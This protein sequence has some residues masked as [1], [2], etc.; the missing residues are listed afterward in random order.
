[1]CVSCVLVSVSAPCPEAMS[2]SPPADEISGS[3]PAHEDKDEL[4]QSV[5]FLSAT[6]ADLSVKCE[7][8]FANSVFCD[9]F[10]WK[11]VVS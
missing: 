7:L 8:L 6:D 2:E 1:M 3:P 11:I 9:Y 10:G 5:E 4:S